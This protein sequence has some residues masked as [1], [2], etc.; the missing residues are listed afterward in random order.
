M[1]QGVPVASL[2]IIAI[3]ELAHPSGAWKWSGRLLRITCDECRC[4]RENCNVASPGRARPAGALHQSAFEHPFGVAEKPRTVAAT[5]RHAPTLVCARARPRTRA[6]VP[7]WATSGRLERLLRLQGEPQPRAK[8]PSPGPKPETRRDVR[9]SPRSDSSAT[10][11]AFRRP[12]QLPRLLPA[13]REFQYGPQRLVG[14]HDVVLL[15]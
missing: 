6:R 13:R 15:R 7:A 4:P 11:N 5:M 3:V 2:A 14:R 12:P 8:E 1:L 10:L 9:R